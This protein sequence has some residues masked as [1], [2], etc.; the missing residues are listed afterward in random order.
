MRVNVCTKGVA[1]YTEGAGHFVECVTLDPFTGMFTGLCF[2]LKH[3]HVL[4]T[5]LKVFRLQDSV[6]RQRKHSLRDHHEDTVYYD[7]LLIRCGVVHTSPYTEWS[8]VQATCGTWSQLE[9]HGGWKALSEALVQTLEEDFVGMH[10]GATP[11]AHVLQSLEVCSS[12][13]Q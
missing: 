3:A 4:Q 10:P 1:Y 12:S 2:T 5:L 8:E 11:D 7:M 13:L 6:L 9:E